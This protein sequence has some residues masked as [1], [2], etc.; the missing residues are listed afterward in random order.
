MLPDFHQFWITEFAE[1]AMFYCNRSTGTVC[2]C[3]FSVAVKIR[4]CH[5]LDV[6]VW[7]HWLACSERWS[8]SLG[9]NVRSRSA[10][11]QS[12]THIC[13]ASSVT[14]NSTWNS[15]IRPRCSS[16]EHIVRNFLGAAI[17]VK[18]RGLRN[19]RAQWDTAAK[20]TTALQIY[21]RSLLLLFT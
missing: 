2:F 16:T 7:W 19:R 9:G 14:V 1:W 13:V 10:A 15:T 11:S 21:T 18:N 6:F 17:D 5:W 20:L 12:K 8:R 4:H 3:F